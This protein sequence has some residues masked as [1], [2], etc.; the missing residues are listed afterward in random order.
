MKKFVL[1][2]CVLRTPTEA[3]FIVDGEFCRKCSAFAEDDCCSEEQKWWPAMA[4]RSSNAT[5][6][7]IS[8][9]NLPPVYGLVPDPELWPALNEQRTIAL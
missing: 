6:R 2:L 9:T 8:E 1:I 3:S 4:G 7:P 5:R